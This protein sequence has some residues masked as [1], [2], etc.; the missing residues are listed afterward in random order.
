[1]A[2][3]YFFDRPYFDEMY[4]CSFYNVDDIPRTERRSTLQGI[5]LLVV[6][7]LDFACLVCTGPLSG[8][9]VLNGVVYCTNPNFIYLLGAVGTGSWYAASTTGFILAMNR[10]IVMLDPELSRRMFDGRKAYAWLI[11]PTIYWILTA[12]FTK[13]CLFSS[14]YMGWF[15]DPH[16]GYFA[17]PLAKYHNWPHTI[18]NFCFLAA[19]VSVYVGFGILLHGRYRMFAKNSETSR[20]ASSFIQILCITVLNSICCIGYVYMQFF[21]P[22]KTTVLLI[23][24]SYVFEQG[25]PS[26]IYVCLNQTIRRELLRGI[27]VRTQHSS[28]VY[29]ISTARPVTRETRSCHELMRRSSMKN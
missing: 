11:P 16:I 27:R 18:H 8:W 4:N 13:P 10:C 22:P 28:K 6:A 20:E 24:F 12:L 7:I 14:I 9:F 5:L 26:F 15:F 3:F 17:D 1:M 19:L 29:Q 21:K 25:F 2:Y 23:S